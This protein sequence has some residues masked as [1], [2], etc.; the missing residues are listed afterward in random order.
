VLDKPEVWGLESISADAVVLRIVVK[1]RTSAKDDVARE[2]RLR[3]KKSL[4]DMDVKLPSLSSVVLTGFE[5]AAS[6]TGSRPPKTKPSPLIGTHAG[7]PAEKA[8][9]RKALRHP[10]SQQL[11]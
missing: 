4:D 1:T 11:P 8:A 7:T 5:G 10:R 2:L 9:P 3:L 6:V